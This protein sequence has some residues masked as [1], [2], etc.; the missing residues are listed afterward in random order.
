MTVAEARRLLLI[1]PS[2][3][4]MPARLN[5]GLT[6]AQAVQIV[7]E[8]V[9]YRSDDADTLRPLMEKR[10]W[11]VVCNQRRPTPEAM[12]RAVAKVEGL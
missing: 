4:S 8:G 3:P 5:P 9:E 12:A 10:V 6:Q 2:S 11:Q 1:A 7:R